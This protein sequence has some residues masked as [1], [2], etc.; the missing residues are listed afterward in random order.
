L[1]NYCIKRAEESGRQFSYRPVS[2]FEVMRAM[3]A[4]GLG[5]GL[6]PEIMMKSPEADPKVAVLPISEAWAQRPLHIWSR[7]DTL[8]PASRLFRDYL[9]S[10]EPS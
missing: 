6:I 9:L 4:A 5:V 10:R 7:D 8:V 3:V 2:S 1:R